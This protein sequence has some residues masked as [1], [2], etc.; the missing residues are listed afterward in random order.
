MLK[1]GKKPYI[2]EDD[3]SGRQSSLMFFQGD[4]DEAPSWSVDC[5]FA[6]GDFGDEQVSPCLCIN[7]IDTDKTS[8]TELIG[9]TF[10]VETVEEC[11]EREDTFYIFEH[12]PLINYE[13]TVIDIKDNKAHIKCHGTLIVDG[14]ADPYTTDEFEIDSWIPVIESVDDWEKF[15]L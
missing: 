9:E 4:E 6:N 2:F 11:D 7:P 14:Y 5:G 10:S 15:G 12:E 13:I 8:P 3:L 1:I